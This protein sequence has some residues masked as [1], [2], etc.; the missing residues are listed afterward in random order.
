MGW[1]D[2]HRPTFLLQCT[3]WKMYKYHMTKIRQKTKTAR[4]EARLTP[5]ALAVMKRAAGLQG[6]PVSGFV[7]AAALE[8][9]NKTISEME[10]IKLSRKASEQVASMLINPPEPDKS[11]KKAA[12]AHKRLIVP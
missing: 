9:A 6:R 11:L 2:L 12:A 10:I 5:D 7:V 8:Q 3:A 1:G 4:I